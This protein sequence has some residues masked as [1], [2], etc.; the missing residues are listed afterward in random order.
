MSKRIIALA[1]VLLLCAGL[2]PSSVFAAEND[3]K[4]ITVYYGRHQ[5]DDSWTRKCLMSVYA[6]GGDLLFSA[7]DLAL[8]SGFELV[9]DED[10]LIYTR[11]NKEIIVHLKENA[12]SCQYLEDRFPLPSKIRHENGEY[13]LSG[14]GMLAWLNVR[15][16]VQD[17]MLM[18]VPTPISYW[19]LD[20][21][22]LGQYEFS[23]STCAQILGLSEK[24]ISALIYTE[25]SNSSV[26]LDFLHGGET[27]I[28]D[29]QEY[30][31]LFYDFFMDRSATARAVGHMNEQNM[32]FAEMTKDM[33]TIM[34]FFLKNDMVEAGSD[35]M[36]E[37]IDAAKNVVKIITYTSLF[38]E[39]NTLKVSM[40][41]SLIRNRGHQYDPE[42]I[43][44]AGQAAE[45]FTDYFSGV[46]YILGYALL[47]AI[48]DEITDLAQT[49]IMELL[50]IA[51]LGDETG[52]YRMARADSYL[53]LSDAGQYISNK[54]VATGSHQELEDVEAHA[55]L[56]LYAVEQAYRAFA[57]HVI[58]VKGSWED[59]EAFLN[60]ASEAEDMYAQF[61]AASVYMQEDVCDF[62]FV[63]KRVDGLIKE[64]TKVQRQSV[65]LS[66]IV[67]TAD[68]G[69][70]LAALMDMGMRDMNWQVSDLD[71]DG[72]AELLISGLAS[73]EHITDPHT[74]RSYIVLD[75]PL[76]ESITPMGDSA[77]SFA[78]QSMDQSKFYVRY[79]S[80]STSTQE[81]TAY[82]W[83]GRNWHTAAQWQHFPEQDLQG[84][85]IEVD[86]YF[87][88]GQRVTQSDYES[89]FLQTL[90]LTR[91]PVYENENLLDRTISGDP[92]DLMQELNAH[93]TENCQIVTFDADQDGD[94]DRVYV[95]SGAADRFSR[96][97][98][99]R[100][101]SGTEV[102]LNYTDEMTT[103]V[104][105]ENLG[106]GIRLR[107]C[108]VDAAYNA[109]ALS[110]VWGI[111]IGS[112]D[113]LYCPEGAPFVKLNRDD[114][115]MN[116]MLK[117]A[118]QVTAES[119]NAVLAGDGKSIDA[120]LGGGHAHMTFAGGV[121]TAGTF[122]NNH[123]DIGYFTP[124]LPLSLYAG[125][126]RAGLTPATEWSREEPMTA[127]EETIYSHYTSDCYYFDN[128]LSQ[129]FHVTLNQ[130]GRGYC[131]IITSVSAE[132]V[133]EVPDDLRRQLG[134]SDDWQP[135]IPASGSM[136]LSTL[137][138]SSWAELQTRMDSFRPEPE[139]Q[140][141]VYGE[142]DGAGID[143]LFSDEGTISENLPETVH[144]TPGQGSF[145]LCEGV[146]TSMTMDEIW[147][148]IQP[149]MKWEKPYPQYG[150]DGEYLYHETSFY[151]F[152]PSTS[153]IYRVYLGYQPA[154]T[155]PAAGHTK[156][157]LQQMVED[158]FNQ[159]I[160]EDGA[161]YVIF[162]SEIID[163]ANTCTLYV[164]GQFP[165]GTDANVLVADVVVDKA[166][167][168]M[169]ID[170]YYE[171]RQ[172]Q[173]FTP[174]ASSE[175]EGGKILRVSVELIAY[176]PSEVMDHF[177]P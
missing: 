156:E 159:N 40:M 29:T 75:G 48:S 113:F 151:Y 72:T 101:D 104:F 165:N 61:L 24:D 155:D 117:T 95:I 86:W 147:E 137:L 141:F 133:T 98:A 78:V 134:I 164:R 34:S 127:E 32:I 45:T 177:Y 56:H 84:N 65:T 3:L 69:V 139:Y 82:T 42:M 106:D 77:F 142:L 158:Y 36:E 54:G 102:H 171:T 140:A 124:Q 119:D 129:V 27:S 60:L 14:A 55:M 166:T 96:Q 160:A 11:N 18:V 148:K 2:F 15:Y 154:M 162:D 150:P 76:V 83:N 174:V 103:L 66:E 41:K 115:M 53:S 17:G 89:K 79:D 19:D 138:G 146:T 85:P 7:E 110:S 71:G 97:I 26:I 121:T 108:R 152:C 125:Q 112:E 90:D 49:D 87:L 5:D 94:K 6:D 13:F 58:D 38:K 123:H 44:A 132:L 64:F 91:D 107:I 39:D 43:T 99:D 28:T 68:Q 59:L 172:V 175:L 167:G 25:K 109:P 70:Y 149:S 10:T 100:F 80:V 67:R 9:F 168:M 130:R 176:P 37:I 144:I 21:V 118:K 62:D 47:S 33:G 145:L 63:Q 35:V 116:L 57:Q 30:Y 20:E 131:G 93:Y 169:T 126:F 52:N 143:I 157:Q 153:L 12:I 170:Y 1:L 161:T 163:G 88:S 135:Y 16:G 128:T 105:A 81:N 31:D 51:G 173:L 136:D 92:A 73:A 46:S 50:D 74:E 8:L 120:I 4:C 23:M 22:D 111:C 114:A 122:F